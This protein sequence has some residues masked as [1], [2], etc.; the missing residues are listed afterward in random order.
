M[1][2]AYKT[3]APFAARLK[4]VATEETKYFEVIRA[5]LVKHLHSDGPQLTVAT[6]RKITSN[7]HLPSFQDVGEA[8]QAVKS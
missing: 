4:G 7:R 2:L 5:V 8:V 6:R 3:A 1:L